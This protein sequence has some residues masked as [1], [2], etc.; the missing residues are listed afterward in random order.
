MPA[1]S[2]RS[3][4]G[5]ACSETTLPRSLAVSDNQAIEQRVG[6][7]IDVGPP[8]CNYLVAAPLVAISTSAVA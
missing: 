7:V 1:L 5:D 4:S 6:G 2:L 3:A 8:V